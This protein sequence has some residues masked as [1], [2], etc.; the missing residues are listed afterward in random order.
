MCWAP[1]KG[2]PEGAQITVNTTGTITGDIELGVWGTYSDTDGIKSTLEI[3]NI[4]HVG[5]IVVSDQRLA[6]QLTI[7]GGRFSTNVGNYVPSGYTCEATGNDYVV[8]KL[9][10]ITVT[11]SE[12]GTASS[13]LIRATEG[14]NIG[15]F[16]NPDEGYELKEVIV[17]DTL[18]VQFKTT[19]H[20]FTM[21]NSDVTVEVVFSK[22]LKQEVQIPDAV[23]DYKK[24]EEV[25][26]E[27]LKENK[28]FEELIQN[29]NVEVKVELS[30]DRVETTEKEEI[31][32]KLEE[33]NL[34]VAKCF[35]ITITVNNKD[36]G[37]VVGKLNELK[38]NIKF[39]I[40]IPEDL[41]G[42]AEGF[43][44]KY[45]IV[46]NHAGEVEYLEGKLSE[47][48]KFISFETDKF[49]TY[50]LAYSDVKTT[51]DNIVG[52]NNS[53]ES[54]GDEIEEPNTEEPN[55][56]GAKAEVSNTE[57][58][59]VEENTNAE[60]IPNTGDN[61]ALYII[62]AVI[63]ILGIIVMKKVNTTKSKH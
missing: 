40:E 51:D 48:G 63:A 53:G 47:D 50:A 52:D 26:L 43:A 35:D 62:L 45:Y 30:E 10:D 19:N 22:I 34:T 33:M 21:P 29:N 6:N 12:G 27:S 31:K 32:E 59:N 61:I 60:N 8:S 44:R 5:N 38:D 9:H 28:E 1:N 56:E 39:T 17:T 46:R 23:E 18:G 57:K 14:R 16:I 36:T 41:P 15:L 20:Y 37:V 25:L 58:S 13:D 49:S 11:Y 4:N 7:T 2:Y 3:Q 55:T 42:I 24:V 54:A